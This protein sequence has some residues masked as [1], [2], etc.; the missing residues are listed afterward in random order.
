MTMM[1]KRA[2]SS[3]SSKSKVLSGH[4]Q[5]MTCFQIFECLH[6]KFTIKFA[7]GQLKLH[8][9]SLTHCR[10]DTTWEGSSWPVSPSQYHLIRSFCCRFCFS[11]HFSSLV[12]F[13]QLQ[14]SQSVSAKFQQCNKVARIYSF[15]ARFLR[16]SVVLSWSVDLPRRLKTETSTG[17]S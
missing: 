9:S 17:T 16:P 10:V 12:N 7:A 15:S 13:I 6:K 2:D 5:L 14:F 1:N 3:T 8:G 11:S 4:R